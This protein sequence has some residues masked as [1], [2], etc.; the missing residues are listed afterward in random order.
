MWKYRAAL[1]GMPL[2]ASQMYVPPES[3]V[4]L[5]EKKAPEIPRSTKQEK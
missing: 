3:G 5:T 1:G 2:S 4:T